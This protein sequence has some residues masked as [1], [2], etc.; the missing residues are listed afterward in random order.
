MEFMYCAGCMK[1]SHKYC[2]GTNTPV[3]IED[4]KFDDKNLKCQRF[5]CDL[6]LSKKKIVVNSNIYHNIQ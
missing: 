6:C 1:P 4:Y 2:Y 3:V 5:L